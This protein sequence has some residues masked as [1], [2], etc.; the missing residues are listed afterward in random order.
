MFDVIPGEADCRTKTTAGLVK[1]KITKSRDKWLEGRMRCPVHKKFCDSVK[2]EL[3]ADSENIWHWAEF[4]DNQVVHGLYL[5]GG[6]S[7]MNMDERLMVILTWPPIVLMV[8]LTQ[9]F[10]WWGK[11]SQKTGFTAGLWKC[12][13]WIL[14][15][16]GAVKATEQGR[17]LKIHQQ[18]TRVWTGLM[19]NRGYFS[20]QN[21]PH[22][23]RH[24]NTF[25]C[26]ISAGLVCT[27]TLIQVCRFYGSRSI[28]ILNELS[29]L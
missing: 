26:H 3:Q 7:H 5:T 16:T 2:A 14:I 27:D 24:L 10:C 12:H 23:F 19:K 29:W 6:V 18:R 25:G 17:A 20:A 22:F 28:F 8:W 4:S 15:V 13:R 11:G 1:Q 21:P 9:I